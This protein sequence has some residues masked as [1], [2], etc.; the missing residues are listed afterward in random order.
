MSVEIIFYWNIFIQTFQ[1]K[2]SNDIV[3]LGYVPITFLDFWYSNELTLIPAILPAI[4]NL[5]KIKSLRKISSYV[6]QLFKIRI[7]LG[8]FSDFS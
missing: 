2:M 1:R 6:A 5:N 3:E 7:T 8:S 4:L